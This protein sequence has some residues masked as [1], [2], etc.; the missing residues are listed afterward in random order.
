MK[1]NIPY[2]RK[3]PTNPKPVYKPMTEIKQMKVEVEK[4]MPQKE[5]KKEVRPLKKTHPKKQILKLLLE[6]KFMTKSQ[7]EKK[8]SWVSDFEKVMDSLFQEELIKKRKIENVEEEILLTTPKGFQFIEEDFKD[9]SLLPK[10]QGNVFTGRVR[11]DLKL[12]DL[13]MRFEELGFIK[14]W[15]SEEMMKEVPPLRELMKDFPDAICRKKDDRAYFLELEISNKGSTRYSDR[16]QEYLD[17]LESETCKNLKIDGVLF[18][19]THE[20]VKET[21]KSKI[22]EG[23]TRISVLPFDR[24]FSPYEGKKKEIQSEEDNSFHERVEEKENALSH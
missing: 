13:R 18:L 20:K 2:T 8:F 5:E 3:F 23:E 7:L 4:V 11:H 24:Y 21:I 6:M 10:P 9:D 14:K 1:Q 19:C 16:I 17:I 22:E 15:T 12:A